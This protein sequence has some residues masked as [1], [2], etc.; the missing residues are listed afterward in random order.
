M[1]NKYNFS[2]YETNPNMYKSYIHKTISIE[3]IKQVNTK[4]NYIKMPNN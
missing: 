3:T 1:T 4:I 2:K